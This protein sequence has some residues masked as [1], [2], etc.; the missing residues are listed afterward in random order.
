MKLHG[1]WESAKPRVF[2]CK[3]SSWKHLKIWKQGSLYWFCI[4]SV[5]TFFILS[6]VFVRGESWTISHIPYIRNRTDCVHLG[7]SISFSFT[8][9]LS[10]VWASLHCGCSDYDPCLDFWEGEP[11]ILYKGSY[12]SLI[13]ALSA[14]SCFD[15]AFSAF[16]T[17]CVWATDKKPALTF[18][19]TRFQSFFPST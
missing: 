11:G 2:P 12:T 4:F 16:L 10:A 17:V 5:L 19:R 1:C 9:P 3:H 13:A 15:P 18:F 7:K 14:L 8:L 6:E